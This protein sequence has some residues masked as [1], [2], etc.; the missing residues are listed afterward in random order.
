MDAIVAAFSIV[1]ARVVTL[2][3]LATGA[4]ILPSSIM[5]AG[6]LAGN[7]TAAYLWLLYVSWGLLVLSIVFGHFTLGC[8]SHVLYKSANSDERPNLY[9]ADV[10]AWA[11]LQDLM[12]AAGG[13]VLLV[14]L[15]FNL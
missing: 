12:F 10:K 1:R 7:E 2:V 14:F 13:I 15:A 9:D 8:L 6:F 5:G 3:T 4:I 11:R